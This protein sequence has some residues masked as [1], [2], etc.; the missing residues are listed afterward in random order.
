M[1]IKLQKGVNLDFT[2]AAS[3]VVSRAIGE[4]LFDG[5]PLP[6]PDAGK[7]PKAV[8]RGRMG[9]RI[10]GYAAYQKLADEDENLTARR[11][12]TPDQKI[13]I[14]FSLFSF[15]GANTIIVLL[16]GYSVQN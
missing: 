3:S 4:N 8:T 14:P 9:G 12:I 16:S 13:C 11:C 15:F 5:S 6:D 7:D 10:G 2:A 1:K